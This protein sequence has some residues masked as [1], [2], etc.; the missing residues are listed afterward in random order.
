MGDVF[1]FLSEM[2]EKDIIDLS[3]GVNLGKI[4]D[5]QIDE[6]GHIIKFSAEPKRLFRRF[7]KAQESTINYQDIVKVGTDVIL[8]K[9]IY[10]N[11]EK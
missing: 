1:L 11:E 5:A 9:T 2:Q 3:S 7:F 10:E 8:V 4:T 6:Q